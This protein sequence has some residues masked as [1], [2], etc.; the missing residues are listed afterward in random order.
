MERLADT[1]IT[2]KDRGGQILWSD[3]STDIDRYSL[4]FDR[5]KRA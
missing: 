5:N 3:K 2:Q 1:R 4:I